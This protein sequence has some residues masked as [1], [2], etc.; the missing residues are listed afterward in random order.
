MAQLAPDLVEALEPVMAKHW[1]PK[2]EYVEISRGVGL[3]YQERIILRSDVQPMIMLG[4]RI[5]RLTKVSK[6]MMYTKWKNAII[7]ME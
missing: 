3:D 6:S 7:A 5:T 4:W 1:V 2:N